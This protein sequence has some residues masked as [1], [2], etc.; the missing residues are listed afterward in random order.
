MGITGKKDKKGT[1]KGSKKP[2]AKKE[3]K[4]FET[5]DF[6]GSLFE[7]AK[8]TEDKHPDLN[9]KCCIEGVL[10]WVA[11]WNKESK[12]GVEYVSLAFTPVQSE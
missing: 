10:Y 7:N 9:G 2:E 1:G 8:K 12:K 11:G 3:Q 5:R 4:A 6:S